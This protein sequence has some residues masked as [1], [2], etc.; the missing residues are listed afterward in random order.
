MVPTVSTHTI[1]ITSRRPVRESVTP[2]ATPAS[3]RRCRSSILREIADARPKASSICT[4]VADALRSA[5]ASA[6]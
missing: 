3:L 4:M 2:V 6:S 1:R 5:S